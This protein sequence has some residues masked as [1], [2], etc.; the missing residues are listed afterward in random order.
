VTMSSDQSVIATFLL[1][2]FTIAI[3]TFGTGLGSVATNPGGP[4]FANGT[5]V[6]LIATPSGGSQFAGWTGDCASFGTQSVC[7]LL[8]NANKSVGAEFR[9]AT[10]YG[11]NVTNSGTGSGTVSRDKPGP[12]YPPGT[13]VTLSAAPTPPSTFAG[14]FGDCSGTGDC[15]LNMNSD[16]FV[17][18]QFD[19]AGADAG[20]GACGA[21]QVAGGDAPDTRGIEMGISHGTFDFS[22]DTYSIPDDIVVSYQGLPLFDTGCVGASGTTTLSFGPGASTQLTVSVSPN[23]AGGTSGTAW[24]YTIGCPK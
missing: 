22:Y 4:A 13:L 15:F 8:V 9:L 20:T 23:C 16:K 21:Q 17:I 14:W 7:T 24:D 1:E 2:T 18:A 12:S 3:N 5:T 11:I 10:G 19:A 6:D